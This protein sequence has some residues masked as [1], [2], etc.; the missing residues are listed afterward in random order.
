MGPLPKRCLRA[1]LLAA[2]FV[3]PGFA[4]PAAA[5]TGEEVSR[6]VA[7]LEKLEPQSGKLTYDEDEADEWFEQDHDGHIVSAGFTRETWKE[8]LDQTFRGY[9]ATIPEAEF[10]ARFAGLTEKITGAPDLTDEQRSEM[11]FFVETKIAEIRQMRAGGKPYA[12]IVRP[13]A[14]QLYELIEDGNEP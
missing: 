6:V 10:E 1:A 13:Y 7:L 14:P 2:A 3:L 4:S 11:R 12:D 8:A 5:L 9:L